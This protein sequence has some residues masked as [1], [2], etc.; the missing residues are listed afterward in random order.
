MLNELFL[1][2]PNTPAVPYLVHLSGLSLTVAIFA[3]K[4]VQFTVVSGILAI[5][6]IDEN[7]TRP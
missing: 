1:G 6:L 7:S 4:V 2:Y 5:V 3:A